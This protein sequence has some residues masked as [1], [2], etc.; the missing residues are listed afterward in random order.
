MRRRGEV[1]GLPVVVVDSG[2]AV[3]RVKD[4]VFDLGQGRL[5]G[6]IVVSRG[7][8]AFLP[9]E[10]V[11]SLGASAVTIGAEAVLVPSFPAPVGA[12]PVGK[13]V[14]TREGQ[15]LGTI[16]DVLF[17]PESGAVWGYQVTAGFISDFVEGKKAVVLTEEIV[18]GPDS[19]VVGD[20]GDVREPG[21]PDGSAVTMT[22]TEPTAPEATGQG[23]LQE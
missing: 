16:D 11:H 22:A 3:G 12:S 1:A 17:D 20:A 4:V 14:L 19:V 21:D 8:R 6:F 15:L 9:F 7:S 23:G 13:S 10:Q 18:E 2:R 5:S